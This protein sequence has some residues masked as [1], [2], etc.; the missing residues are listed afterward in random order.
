LA[1]D[2][3][4][5]QAKLDDL[6]TKKAQETQAREDAEKKLEEI[7]KREA[8]VQAASILASNIEAGVQLELAAVEAI[9]A[10]AAIP[11]VGV[12]LG[13]GFAALIISTFLSIKNTIKS[14]TADVPKFRHGGGKDLK[15]QALQ[16]PSHE[17]GGIGLYNDKTG[18]KLAEYEGNEYLFAINQKSKGVYVPLL[19]AI[20]SNDAENI[21]KQTDSIYGAKRLPDIS[22]TLNVARKVHAQDIERR[23]NMLLRGDLSK[24]D[25][26]E[27]IAENTKP[28][29][30]ETIIETEE[31]RII[32]TQGRT[33]KIIKH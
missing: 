16:G 29:E 7:R 2:L 3:A 10:H 5:Q 19:E 13:L 6:K 24:L 23:N 22:E 4:N 20:N 33:R 11:F 26:L 9:K 27:T 15:G 32:K 30:K 17:N 25:H 1:N 28:V 31:Y 12:A 21:R 8:V 14:A 18:E